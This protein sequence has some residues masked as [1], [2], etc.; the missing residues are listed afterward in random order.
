MKLAFLLSF[1]HLLQDFRNQINRSFHQDLVFQVPHG[2]KPGTFPTSLTHEHTQ[3]ALSP[4][5]NTSINWRTGSFHGYWGQ[6]G[7]RSDA[8]AGRLAALD[9]RLS[10]YDNIPNQPQLCGSE[11]SVSASAS[12]SEAEPAA[13]EE[14]DLSRLLDGEDVFSALDSVLERIS[15]LQQLVS[16]WS[17]S[18]SKDKCQRGSSPSSFLSSSSS[19]QVS[20]SSPSHIHLEVQRSEEEVEDVD[21][22]VE[23]EPQPSR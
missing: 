7:C 21:V 3:A 1:T 17:E 15:R 6:R 12:I 4:V 14:S 22:D 5:L 16:S 8:V 18:L 23:D 2:H 11:G 20:P 9:H 10:V 19:S 13:E